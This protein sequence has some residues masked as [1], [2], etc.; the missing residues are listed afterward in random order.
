MLLL[1]AIH[2]V[3]KFGKTSILTPKCAERSGDRR[4]GCSSLAA[5]GVNVLSKIFYQ[6]LSTGSTKEDPSRH[7]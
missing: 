7:D 3:V 5:G 1:C 2:D 6:L 4:V